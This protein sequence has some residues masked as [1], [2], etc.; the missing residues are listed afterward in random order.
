MMAFL[1]PYV[2][3]YNPG[4]LLFGSISHIVLSMVCAAAAMAAFVSTAE[5]YL[6]GPISPFW[7]VLLFVA[8]ALLVLGQPIMALIG[9]AM[10]LVIVPWIWLGRRRPALRSFAPKGESRAAVS[11]K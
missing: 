1:I 11:G 10:L 9:G 4:I 6:F 8:G 3:I 5:G 2:F 7:R